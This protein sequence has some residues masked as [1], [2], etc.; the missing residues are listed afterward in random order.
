MFINRGAMDRQIVEYS[1]NGTIFC[2]KKEQNIGIC[3]NMMSL[4]YAEKADKKETI[5]C[6]SIYMKF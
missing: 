5:P 4:K 6:V 3:N 1:Y 2:N